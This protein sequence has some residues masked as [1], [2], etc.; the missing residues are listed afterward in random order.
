[1]SARVLASM[2][3]LDLSSPVGTY[4]TRVLSDLGADVVLVEPPEGDPYRRLGPFRTRASGPEASLAFGYYQAGKRSIVLD[5]DDSADR[6]V[7]ERLGHDADVVVISPA[8]ARPTPGF[9]AATGTLAWASPDAVV[10]S[11]TPF[12]VTGPY[13]RRSA[14]HLTSFAQSGGMWRAGPAGTPPVPIPPNLHWHIASAHAAVAIL[15]ALGVRERVGGQFVDV[16]AQEVEQYQEV[17]WEAYHFQG[18]RPGARTIPIGVPPTGVWVCRDGSF[19]VAAHQVQHWEAF[20]ELLDHP[21]E[22]AEPA[23]TDMATRQLIFDGVSEIVASLL[24]PRSRY[25]LFDRGQRI[26]L[27]VGL[28]NTPAQFVAD[29]QLAARDFFV[30]LGR[31]ETGPLLAPGPAVRTVPALF[32]PAGPAPLLDEH[33]AELRT[34]SRTES[35]PRRTAAEPTHADAPSRPLEGV[36]VLSLGEFVAGNYTAQILAALGAEVVKIESRSRPSNVRTQ[37]FND[38]PRLATEPSGATN[39]PMYASFSRGTLGVAIEMGTDEGREVFRRLAAVTDIVIENFGATVMTS[40]GCAYDDLRRHNPGLVMVSLSGYGRTGPRAGY[41]A[42]G[43][44]IANFTGIGD[45]WWTNPTYGDFLTAAHAS[46]AILAA[47][48]HVAATGEGVLVDAS[49]VEVVASMA[50]SLYL[51]VLVNGE[52]GAT[53]EPSAEDPCTLLRHVFACT[54][55]DRWAAVEATTLDDWNAV[56]DVVDRPDLRAAS[57]ADA[58][59][60]GHDLRDALDEWGA[61]RTTLSAAHLLSLAGV[62]AASVANTEESYHDPQLNH[63]HFPTFS[64]HP[65]IGFMSSPGPPYRLSVTP[66]VLDRLGP[67][68]GQHTRDVLRRWA[69]MSDAEVDALVSA[70]IAFDLAA[71]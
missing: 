39:T 43:S 5:L 25:E 55:D 63:R 70:G 68:V 45:I 41:L 27:P 2:R 44:N 19:D 18:L 50:A 62:P 22:L 42:Y 28:L 46:G 71:G 34:E 13:A 31:T 53:D 38:A 36:R 9:D 7:L 14:T 65:D 61:V 4:C 37:P 3:V 59:A 32:E 1:V 51:D 58:A 67:R 24:A 30:D 10:C 54:G 12:G 23:L 48:R 60:T 66:A 56:C 64:V 11:I 57:T 21:A 6:A 52:H 17:L 35:R 26:G 15:A 29:E 69:D 8:P 49:Q 20:L 40:W 16:S 33:G 47:R